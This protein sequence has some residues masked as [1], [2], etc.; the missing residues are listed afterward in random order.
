MT[1]DEAKLWN[2]YGTWTAMLNRWT[3]AK[4]GRH[5]DVEFDPTQW[6]I[7]L[8]SGYAQERNMSWGITV[9]GLQRPPHEAGFTLKLPRIEDHPTGEDL[10]EAFRQLCLGAARILGIKLGRALLTEGQADESD[11]AERPRLEHAEKEA[12]TLPALDEPG[13]RPAAI[14]KKKDRP[15]RSHRSRGKKKA[16]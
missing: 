3:A 9:P 11:S 5:I 10:D 16:H 7:R 14:R 1:E 15:A 2:T 13:R 6:V 12:R 4:L 8:Y